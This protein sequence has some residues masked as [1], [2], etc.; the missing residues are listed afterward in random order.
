MLLALP[1]VLNLPYSNPIPNPNP[2]PKPNPNPQPNPNQ[3][4]NLPYVWFDLLRMMWPFGLGAS[5]PNPNPNLNPNPSPNPSPNPNPIRTPNAG[6]LCRSSSW[7][8]KPLRA[9][10]KGGRAKL[11]RWHHRRS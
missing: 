1:P 9:G 2:N 7:L 8:G 4:L 6:C 5:N 3:V 11:R 10:I